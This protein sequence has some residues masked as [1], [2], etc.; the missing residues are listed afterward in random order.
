MTGEAQCPKCSGLLRPDPQIEGSSCWNC[1]QTYYAN[2]PEPMYNRNRLKA[3]CEDDDATILQMRADG[4]TWREI[5]DILG[6]AEQSCQ[7]RE[8]WI[9]GRRRRR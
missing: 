2:N 3:W 1:G 5:G 9:Q 6:R 4:K 8:R 7:M